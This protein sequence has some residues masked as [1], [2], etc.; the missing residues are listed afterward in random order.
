ME[1][2]PTQRDLRLSQQELWR[3]A[4]HLSD[5]PFLWSEPPIPFIDDVLSHLRNHHAAR[6]LDAGCGD[7]RNTHRIITDG[8]SVTG[9]DY[10]PAA[11]ELCH[12]RLDLA[13]S[14]NYV[15][16]RSDL[17]SLPFPPAF[18]DAIVCIEVLGHLTNLR[19]VLSEFHR[20]LRP[21]G[22]FIGSFFSHDDSTKGFFMRPLTSSSFLYERYGRSVYYRYFDLP[23]V[24]KE[25]STAQL[26]TVASSKVSWH[27]PA[28]EG[29][30]GEPHDHT[31]WIAI[32]TNSSDAQPSTA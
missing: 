24:E 30:R 5:S 8:F 10:S 27:D 17:S 18:F 6:V 26:T 23:E 13:G 15:L 19:K 28:H 2:P 16:V 31:S 14:H 7:G 29:F 21:G 12:R 32:A 4:Y 22:V 25:L 20:I 1:R 3:T 11:L 9:V